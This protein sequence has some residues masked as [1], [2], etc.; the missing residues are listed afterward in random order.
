LKCF[1]SIPENLKIIPDFADIMNGYY[2]MVIPPGQKT[3]QQIA[4]I[5][6]QMGWNLSKSLEG[7]IL[8]GYLWKTPYSI[9]L[10]L[11]Q[12]ETLARSDLVLSME[13]IYTIQ[14]IGIK[15]KVVPLDRYHPQEMFK[16]LKNTNYFNDYNSFLKNR[17]GTSGANQRITVYLLWGI[18]EDK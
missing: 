4:T 6:N 9:H 7:E 14:A 16:N 13:D 12:S 18:V 17:F 1:L 5:G 11:F 8:E 10:T 3:M 15:K 2:L